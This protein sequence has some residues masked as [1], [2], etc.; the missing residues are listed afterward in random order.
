MN[1]LTN[2]I[3][4]I[5][6]IALKSAKA[7]SYAQKIKIPEITELDLCGEEI[8]RI[9]EHIEMDDWMNELFYLQFDDL[10]N[11]IVLKETAFEIWE[12]IQ[13][14]DTNNAHLEV[15]QNYGS[16]GALFGIA[17]HLIFM[18]LD[19]ELFLPA[20][21]ILTLG[22]CRTDESTKEIRLEAFVDEKG[23]HKYKLRGVSLPS[24]HSVGTFLLSLAVEPLQ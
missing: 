18:A 9:V 8:R 21:F 1:T 2:T 3:S 24:M 10:Q 20:G 14:T 12:T 13:A 11:R 7:F 5:D 15:K 23:E 16:F 17:T 6:M 4:A 22:Y 19:K